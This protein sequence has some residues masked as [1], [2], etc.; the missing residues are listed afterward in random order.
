MG[1][2]AG[3]VWGVI[4]QSAYSLQARRGRERNSN[5][6]KQCSIDMAKLTAWNLNKASCP[7]NCV[8][9]LINYCGCVRVFHMKMIVQVYKL[10]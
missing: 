9:D 2:S 5:N 4:E 3:H 10:L 6:N 7:F 1:E 8:T